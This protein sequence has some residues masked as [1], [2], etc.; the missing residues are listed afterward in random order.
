MISEQVAIL[1][2]SAEAF[3]KLSETY[4]IK[5]HRR[6]LGTIARS[7]RISARCAAA[8]VRI[9]ETQNARLPNYNK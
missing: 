9:S 8:I 3:E 5:R 4:P 7:L 1:N 2:T 6:M